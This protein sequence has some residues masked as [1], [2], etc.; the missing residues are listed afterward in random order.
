MSGEDPTDERKHVVPFDAMAESLHQDGMPD[1]R[2]VRADVHLG[3][4]REPTDVAINARDRRERAFPRAASV[5]VVD[6]GP[7][8]DGADLANQ[9]V[10]EHAFAKTRS[11]DR[12]WLR[13]AD[14]ESM[15]LAD[16]HGPIQDLVAEFGDPAFEIIQE[17]TNFGAVTFPARGE[18]GR[19]REVVASRD[20]FEI[21][22]HP[23]QL[24]FPFPASLTARSGTMAW[25]ISRNGAPYFLTRAGPIP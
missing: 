24:R 7:V 20:V 13:V 16:P 11:E 14:L 25:R 17:L 22:A 2:E 18:K 9:R 19:L 12:A 5:G 8:E 3:I 10:M 1:A 4:P 15:T 23:F 6:E 21:N